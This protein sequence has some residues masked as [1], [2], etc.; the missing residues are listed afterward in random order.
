MLN[1]WK[2]ITKIKEIAKHMQKKH[3]PILVPSQR[4]QDSRHLLQNLKVSRKAVCY[5]IQL[6]DTQSQY[7]SAYVVYNNIQF[8]TVLSNMVN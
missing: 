4:Y 3:R 1:V 2:M 6:L 8:R 7:D 5:I